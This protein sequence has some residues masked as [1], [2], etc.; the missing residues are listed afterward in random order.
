M[1]EFLK[2]EQNLSATTESMSQTTISSIS[3]K[4][5]FSALRHSYL[6]FS[7]KYSVN[8]YSIIKLRDIIIIYWIL[9]IKIDWVEFERKETSDF[10]VLQRSGVKC[11]T[12]NDPKVCYKN[13]A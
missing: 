11:S 8:N 1:S 2:S 13:E 5:D 9:E 12:R 6:K 10:A 4:K 3:Y 7:E